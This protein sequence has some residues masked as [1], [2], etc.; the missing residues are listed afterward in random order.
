LSFAQKDCNQVENNL[1]IKAIELAIDKRDFEKA[2]S[3]IKQITSQ[4][5]TF[6]V[7]KNI[8]LS[9]VM[10]EQN[11]LESADSL[12]KITKKSI[13][14]NTCEALK[15]RYYFALA[16]YQIKTEQADSALLYLFKVNDIAQGVA[17]WEYKAKALGRIAFVFNSLM[18]EPSKSL[19]YNKQSI[20]EIKKTARENLLVLFELNKLSYYGR[21]FDNTQDER[22]LDSIYKGALTALKLAKKI[23]ISQRI[24]QTYSLMAGV[25]FLKKNYAKAIA[26]CDS[27][28]SS[29]NYVNDAK[30]LHALFT[31]KSDIYIELKDYKNALLY[32]DSS[33]YYGQKEHNTLAIQSAYE[34]LYEIEK[35]KGNFIKSLQYHEKLKLLSDSLHDIEKTEI[36]NELEKKYNQ[37]QNENKIKELSHQ[38]ELNIIRNKVIIAVAIILFLV[39]IFVFNYR[40]SQTKMKVLEA[41]QRLNRLR[42][43]PHFFFNALASLQKFSMEENSQEFIASYIAK[44]SKIM[45]QSLESTF[46]EFVSLEEEITFIENYLQVQQLLNNNKFEYEINEHNIEDRSAIKMPS[47]LLQPFLE[48]AIEHGFGGIKEGGFIEIN[49]LIE[50]SQLKFE[51]IDN[52][53]QNNAIKKHAEHKSRALGIIKD[54]VFILYAHPYL[55]QSKIIHIIGKTKLT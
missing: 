33:L 20:A 36:T 17:N 45:R 41:E 3:D 48:N 40:N 43:N 44:L 51:I 39:L 23:N 24:A 16:L 9:Q 38:Q 19:V 6:E 12:L 46:T 5:K 13:Q 37:I 47:M 30:N 25:C 32:A 1:N 22:Y 11:Q 2:V 8:A 7:F 52:G 34:R 50:K 31:K 42:M 28:L 15:L 18:N 10:A 21:K 35:L 14:K 49:L 29:I 54:R 27:G 4:N 26:Y 53:E 55:Y